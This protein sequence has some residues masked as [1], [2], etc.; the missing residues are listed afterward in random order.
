M[1]NKVNCPDSCANKDQ[2][3]EACVSGSQYK[4]TEDPFDCD[5]ESCARR[6]RQ[7]VDAGFTWVLLLTLTIYF[8]HHVTSVLHIRVP[9]S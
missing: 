2:E 9:H 7:I 5:C 1:D 8:C 6:Q 4:E 3:C